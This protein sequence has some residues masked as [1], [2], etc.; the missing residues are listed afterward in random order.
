MSNLRQAGGRGTMTTLRTALLLTVLVLGCNGL[1]KDIAD[2]SPLD[3][4]RLKST[5]DV[6][7]TQERMKEMNE[8]KSTEFGNFAKTKVHQALRKSG[9]WFSNA[10]LPFRHFWN[11][12]VN[13]NSNFLARFNLQNLF[14]SKQTDSNQLNRSKEIQTVTEIDLSFNEHFIKHSGKKNI[15]FGTENVGSSHDLHA[16]FETDKDHHGLVG[17]GKLLER[18][19]FKARK[20]QLKLVKNEANPL[21]IEEQL[22]YITREQRQIDHNLISNVQRIFSKLLGSKFAIPVNPQQIMNNN[23]STPQRLSKSS[24]SFLTKFFSYFMGSTDNQDDSDDK[25]LEIELET[26]NNLVDEASTDLMGQRILEKLEPV[27]TDT[28]GHSNFSVG[29]LLEV[30]Q[31]PSGIEEKLLSRTS[32]EHARELVD[33]FSFYEGLSLSNMVESLSKTN[34]S[35]VSEY[36]SR[37][38]SEVRS[39]LQQIWNLSFSPDIESTDLPADERDVPSL[40]QNPQPKNIN[41]SFAISTSPK[42]YTFVGAFPKFNFTSPFLNITK[43]AFIN[44][45][46]GLLLGLP[47]L[48]ALTAGALLGLGGVLAILIASHI[49]YKDKDN[50][51]EGYGDEGYGHTGYD[52]GHVIVAVPTDDGYGK[53]S[54]KSRPKVTRHKTVR[55]RIQK[56]R[57]TKVRPSYGTIH[58]APKKKGGGG[59]S[60][61]KRIQ[62]GDSYFYDD[63]EDSGLYTR[64][65]EFPDWQYAKKDEQPRYV[66]LSSR[67]IK[68]NSPIMDSSRLFD[69]S[70]KEDKQS[71][72]YKWVY[73]AR[74]SKEKRQKNEY[75]KDKIYE[76]SEG[77]RH[78]KRDVFESWERGRKEIYKPLTKYSS[79]EEVKDGSDERPRADKPFRGTLV[80]EEMGSLEDILYRGNTKKR[81]QS[82]RKNISKRKS[83]SERDSIGQYAT[84]VDT[85]IPS[86]DKPLS[87]V[88]NIPGIEWNLESSAVSPEGVSVKD[89]VIESNS[90]LN[91]EWGSSQRANSGGGGVLKS[92]GAMDARRKLNVLLDRYRQYTRNVFTAENRNG[93][94][95]ASHLT[96]NSYGNVST[97]DQVITNETNNTPFQRRLLSVEPEHSEPQKFSSAS[98]LQTSASSVHLIKSV[99]DTPLPEM[100]HTTRVRSRSTAA[101]RRTSDTTTSSVTAAPPGE[102][103]FSQ[104]RVQEQREYRVPPGRRFRL[105][106]PLNMP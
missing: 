104:Q 79:Q 38:G 49:H 70:H 7:A 59:Y 48:A 55:G 105:A 57:T 21:V 27:L 102:Q 92:D 89:L 67:E 65:L 40:L 77:S 78:E 62:K 34:P 26:E 13:F 25:D 41:I 1:V 44:N 60:H 3:N 75:H 2:A 22:P 30:L 39:S 16:E 83:G 106:P 32:I 18:Q 10:V 47:L 51:Y 23:Y 103:L 66:R 15:T 91:E 93:V 64:S 4:L 82:K 12:Q 84:Q 37:V 43:P 98:S 86:K 72:E 56:A 24:G 100:P 85:I 99:L 42:N 87:E 54:K 61:R 11:S 52:G 68:K 5:K 95:L 45:N 31:N 8:T 53:K 6:L 63:P 69:S 58:S 20:L 73:T 19:P 101:S 74:D 97:S 94:P 76:S 88:G 9:A 50:D 36:L 29:E 81:Q 96:A 28:F 14:W 80:L 35:S 46:T 33:V 17:T 71:Q 90:P